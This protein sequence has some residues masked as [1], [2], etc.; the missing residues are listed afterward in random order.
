[1][2]NHEPAVY[3]LPRG[4]ETI[5]VG[6][7]DEELRARVRIALEACGYGILAAPTGAEALRYAEGHRGSI[8]LLICQQEMPDMDGSELA[9]RVASLADRPGQPANRRRLGV[10]LLA[11]D[12]E[13]AQAGSLVACLETPIRPSTLVATVRQIIDAGPVIGSPGHVELYG[14]F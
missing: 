2:E 3:K 6:V 14:V 10:L 4:S 7:E 9:R 13:A 12:C 5:L 1:M 11:D 8:S